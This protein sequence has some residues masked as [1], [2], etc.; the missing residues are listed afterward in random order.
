M[1]KSVAELVNGKGGL[2]HMEGLQA[3]SV[4]PQATITT[5]NELAGFACSFD[6]AA[7]VDTRL[8]TELGW[9]KHVPHQPKPK[10]E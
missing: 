5:N 4:M 3:I 10:V 9:N 6:A 1:S 2:A 7:N 8:L